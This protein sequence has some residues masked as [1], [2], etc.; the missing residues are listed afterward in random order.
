MV[1]CNTSFCRH[2]TQYPDGVVVSHAPPGST[3]HDGAINGQI[4]KNKQLAAFTYLSWLM[5]DANMIEAVLN[6]PSWPNGFI[7]SFVKPSLWVPSVWTQ[8]GWRD[9]TLS[10]VLATATS[11]MDHTNAYFGM[12]LP[13]A[14]DY[15]R[16]ALEIL[17]PFWQS[18]GEFKDI[19]QDAV[20]W[21][22]LPASRLHCR[23]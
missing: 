5:R 22:S 18:T 13:N 23:K 7:G 19:G 17:I 9:P 11:N 1:K 21:S 3:F 10:M 15:F 20:R 6:P 12:R 2:A 16:V 14:Q 4:D 8:H